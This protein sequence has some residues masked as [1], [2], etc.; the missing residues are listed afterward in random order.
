MIDVPNEEQ[1]VQ[2]QEFKGKPGVVATAHI[3]KMDDDAD[4]SLVITHEKPND[5]RYYMIIDNPHLGIVPP[6]FA[7]VGSTLNRAANGSLTI[8]QLNIGF[9][10][11]RWERT[12]TISYRNGKYVISGFTY[13]AWDAHN[14]ELGQGCDYNLITGKGIRNGKKVNI[15]TR[16]LDLQSFSSPE[17]LESCKGW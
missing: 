4:A 2:S 7:G 11:S 5:A 16:A 6:E 10:R 12:L 17:K 14:P 8:E 3:V 1:V 13:S 9:S 15:K